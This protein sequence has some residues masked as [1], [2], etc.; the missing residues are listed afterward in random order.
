MSTRRKRR[1]IVVRLLRA[2]ARAARILMLAASGLGPAPPRLE[3]QGRAP[4]EQH[5]E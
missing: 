5:E 4:T 2:V 1:S 3:P